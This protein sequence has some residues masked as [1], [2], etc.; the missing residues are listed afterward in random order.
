MFYPFKTFKKIQNFYSY[1]FQFYLFVSSVFYLYYI[2]ILSIY[3]Y[4]NS[5]HNVLSLFS[6]TCSIL[7]SSFQ[8]VPPHFTC[9]RL[10][11]MGG[12]HHFPTPKVRAPSGGYW[13]N[14]KYWKLNT[15]IGV[16]IGLAFMGGIAVYFEKRTVSFLNSLYVVLPIYQI[17]FSYIPV[18]LPICSVLNIPQNIK[19]F[20]MKSFSRT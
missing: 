2:I 5:V 9:F 1:M 20:L 18:L 10:T 17:S 12:G 4:I 14:P 11:F 8:Y 16:V 6:K 7:K 3:W 13:P 19:N 15:F